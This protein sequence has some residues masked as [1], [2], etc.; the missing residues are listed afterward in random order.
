MSPAQQQQVADMLKLTFAP[1]PD[2]DAA[3]AWQCLEAN[4]GI[5]SLWLSY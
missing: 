4:R 2:E 5:S 3:Y 1:Y